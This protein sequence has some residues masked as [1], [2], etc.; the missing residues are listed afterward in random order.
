MGWIGVITGDIVDSTEILS[1]GNRDRLLDI[2]HSTISNVNTLAIANARIEIYR[3]DSFQI[4][5]DNAKATV[6]TAIALRSALTANSGANLR[7]D[8]RMGLGIGKGEFITDSVVE[9]DGEAFRLSGQAFDMLDKNSRM[10]IITPDDDFN[11]ELSVS[12]NFADDIVSGWTQAQASV[13]YP[14][15]MAEHT[16]QKDLAEIIGKT[17]QTISKLLLN[18]KAGNIIKYANRFRRKVSDLEKQKS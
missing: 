2:L 13:V 7:W 15:M 8:A 5:T 12:T 16:S 1:S 14:L 11:D 10:C 18:A 4:I 17:Q 9:S 6:W 3:G